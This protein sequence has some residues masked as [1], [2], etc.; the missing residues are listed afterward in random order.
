MF[1][2]LADLAGN[3]AMTIS[4]APLKEQR[5]SFLGRILK[6]GAGLAAICGLPQL[7]IGQQTG[8]CGRIAI[9]GIG[10]GVTGR[11]T[12]KM[13]RGDLK[14]AMAQECQR[15]CNP[16]TCPGSEVCGTT[17]HTL[18]NLDVHFVQGLGWSAFADLTSCSCGCGSSG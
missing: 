2:K 11:Q 4:V 9:T 6:A 14:L 10:I 13:A 15:R 17:G 7:A 1:E 5:R 12:D 16:L 18:A 8:K 3:L